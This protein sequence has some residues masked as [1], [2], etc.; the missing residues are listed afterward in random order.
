LIAVRLLRQ[1]SKAV[2]LALAVLPD[3]S[4]TI[5]GTWIEQTES[6]NFG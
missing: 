2:D 3:R 5:L 6:A 1:R 4:R